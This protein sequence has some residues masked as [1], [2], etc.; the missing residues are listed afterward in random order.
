MSC[1][2]SRI[3][4][5]EN[6]LKSDPSKI[7]NNDLIYYLQCN[8]KNKI[9]DSN[10]LD[11][12][13]EYFKKIN[14]SFSYENIFVN[15]SNYTSI[16]VSIIGLLI[17]FYYYYPRF[18]KVGFIGVSIGL[19]SLSNLFSQI[20]GLYNNFFNNIGLYFLGL[21]ILIYF[22]FF[23][24][25]NKLNHISLFFIS[26]II[27]YLLINYVLRIILTLP[28][29]NNVY[30]QYRATLNSASSNSVSLNSD[31]SDSYTEYNVLLESAC[32]EVMKRYNL[33]LPSGNMLYSYLTEF[34]IGD[35][36]GMYSDF[37]TNLFGPFISI[38]ILWLLG[39]FLT[40]IKTNDIDIFPIVGINQDSAKYFLCQANY[41]LPK[42][43]NVNLLIHDLLDKHEFD[44]KTYSKME[45]ALLRISKE[46]LIKYNPKF[47]RVEINE[48]NKK[49]I[50]DNLKNNKIY[51]EINKI[52]KKENFDFDINYLDEMK[53]YI[54]KAEIPYKNKLEMYNLLTHINNTLSIINEKIDNSNNSKCPG[55]NEENDLLVHGLTHVNLAKTELLYDKDLNDKDKKILE[56]LTNEY[57][58]NFTDNLN[59]K[60]GTLY[61]YHYNIITY[62]LFGSKARFISNKIFKYLVGFI[63][64]WL[65]LVKPIG[66]PWLIIKYM[67]SE[68]Y[69]FKEL[70]ENMTN[71]SV[72]W[73][74][75][76][77]GLDS[78]YFEDTI[79]KT[80]NNEETSLVTK[81][82]NLLYTVLIFII[83]AP[84]LY[85]YNT[86]TFGFTLS[87]SWYNILYQFV[88]IANILGNNYCLNNGKSL[89]MYNIY[90]F[91]VFIIIMIIASVIMYFTKK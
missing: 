28:I 33:K 37:F 29:K 13:A 18:Y 24:T 74:Y 84:L 72:I 81:G 43:L 63:S 7:S 42:E 47:K 52:L 20:N 77:M 59:L 10:N 51:I 85:F 55:V 73:K 68:K 90:F 1:D 8:S 69:G 4:I 49:T 70:L 3:N 91:I 50:L 87:P 34:E 31:K 82:L 32:Y 78:S 53:D 2:I 58:K 17:P 41:I 89:L 86:T 6:N 60:D 36:S 64:T 46:L 71:N 48:L 25:L 62:A 45:K 12:T 88:F 54:N 9:L 76:S 5:I 23:V 27:S 65:L 26:A 75:F 11:N 79:K 61:G 15:K 30:N 56:N 22:I 21:T 83:V 16:I 57:I 66:S 35:N 67:L 80:K 14:N 19:L 38:I 39:N 40:Q 44:E